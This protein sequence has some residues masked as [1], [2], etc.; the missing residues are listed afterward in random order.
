MNPIIRLFILI[1]LVVSQLAYA[2]DLLIDVQKLDS[3]GEVSLNGEWYFHFGELLEPVQ[4]PILIASEQMDRITVPSDWSRFPEISSKENFAHGQATYA[5]PVKVKGIQN[6]PIALYVEQIYDN[7]QILWLPESSTKAL[8][9]ATSRGWNSNNQLSMEGQFYRLPRDFTDGLLVI[10]V[11]KQLFAEGGILKPISIV[12]EGE[13]KLEYTQFIIFR[14]MLAGA[15]L[16]MCLHYFIQFLTWRA[17]DN[18][19]YLSLFCFV[20]ALRSA[21]S[22]GMADVVLMNTHFFS[23]QILYRIEYITLIIGPAIF[24]VFYNAFLRPLV[25]GLILK[26]IQ[27]QSLFLVLVFS[28][29]PFDLMSSQLTILQ[30]H[31]GIW[32]AITIG[33]IIRAAINK[34]RFSRLVMFSAIVMGTAVSHDIYSARSYTYNIYIVEFATFAFLILQAHFVGILMNENMRR[35]ILLEKEKQELE[36]SHKEVVQENKI[37][38]LTGLSNRKTFNQ[39]VEEAW[40]KALVNQEPISLIFVDIDHFKQVN[41]KFGHAIGDEVIIF[42]AS[43]LYR[44]KL[45]QSDL[46]ARYG[47][48]E[49]VIALPSTDLSGALKIAEQI[50]LEIFQ[51]EYQTAKIALKL[52]ASFGVHS[53]I[54]SQKNTLPKALELADQALYLAKNSGRNRVCHS[55]QLSEDSVN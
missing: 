26:F 50:R 2:A 49:F 12:N 9:I 46:V 52:T 53:E 42:F 36:A 4:I 47:G 41:D 3:G 54:P 35:S 39:Y 19:L 13:L 33:F 44:Y 6:I 45:R 25:P 16:I 30:L 15:L 28:F 24:I 11:N 48:E 22:S 21:T 10:H 7:Y 5:L 18:A 27:I 34:I 1:I 32:S 51:S 40:Q 17:G 14:A 37:D 43:I 20:V 55:E 38:H 8:T 29:I 31:I 23:S